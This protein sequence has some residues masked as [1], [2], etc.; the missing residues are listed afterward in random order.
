MVVQNVW[1]TPLTQQQGTSG[2]EE[3]RRV[4]I[5]TSGVKGV[6]GGATELLRLSLSQVSF[7]FMIIVQE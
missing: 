1:D 5:D 2:G 4:I 7:L 6:L 3:E